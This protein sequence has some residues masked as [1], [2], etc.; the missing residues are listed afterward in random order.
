MIVAI[1]PWDSRVLR[2]Q[3]ENTTPLREMWS[4]ICETKERTWDCLTRVLVALRFSRLSNL[5]QEIAA[6]GVD[7]GFGSEGPWQHVLCVCLDGLEFFVVHNFSA[8][9]RKFCIYLVC[10]QDNEKLRSKQVGLQHKR[11]VWQ[12]WVFECRCVGYP[13]VSKTRIHSV[14]DQG[15]WHQQ[16]DVLAL[17]FTQNIF[18][19]PSWRVQNFLEKTTRYSRGRDD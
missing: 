3:A 10:G 2:F 19:F 17:F 9:F 5:L 7:P 1:K 14:C 11:L 8:P 18:T 6:A 12:C 4:P 16:S 15:T 13:R